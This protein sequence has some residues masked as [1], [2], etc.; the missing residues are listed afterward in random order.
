MRHGELQA[1]VCGCGFVAW[2]VYRLE[3]VP[4]GEVRFGGREGGREVVAPG[5]CVV[6][7]GN[8]CLYPL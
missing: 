3:F 1:G 4:E 6:V 2:R 8:L 7:S 5:G